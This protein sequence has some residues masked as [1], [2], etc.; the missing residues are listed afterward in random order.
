MAPTQPSSAPIKVKTPMTMSPI[1]GVCPRRCRHSA[2]AG[3]RHTRRHR[4]RRRS[5]HGPAPPMRAP[6]SQPPPPSW[7][8]PACSPAGKHSLECA[9]AHDGAVAHQKN[10]G[11]QGGPP[12]LRLAVAA[13]G[14]VVLEEGAFSTLLDAVVLEHAPKGLGVCERSRPDADEDEG[15][16]HDEHAALAGAQTSARCASGRSPQTCTHFVTSMPRRAVL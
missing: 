2:H 3:R 8:C 11:G 15:E 5:K 13:H 6:H 9:R 4:H 14:V 12:R 7:P 10:L 16:E 1:D